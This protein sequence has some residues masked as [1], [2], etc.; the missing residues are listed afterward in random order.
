[1]KSEGFYYQLRATQNEN[2][3]HFNQSCSGRLMKLFN[4]LPVGTFFCYCTKLYD[5]VNEKMEQK[6]PSG[7]FYVIQD[8]KLSKL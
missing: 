3:A 8:K 2:A 1:M 5:H 4:S 7:S 6:N